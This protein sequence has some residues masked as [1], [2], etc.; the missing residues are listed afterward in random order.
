MGEGGVQAN[1]TA[2]E[3]SA[4]RTSFL[5]QCFTVNVN[6]TFLTPI[7]V[8]HSSEDILTSRVHLTSFFSIQA[9][10][11]VRQSM[12]FSYFYMQ[13]EANDNRNHD[14]SMYSSIGVGEELT[15]FVGNRVLTK[16][17]I[18]RHIDGTS[19]STLDCKYSG[20]WGRSYDSVNAISHTATFR[21][22]RLR[23]RC[24]SSGC[25]C[26]LWSEGRCEHFEQFYL[27]NYN[28]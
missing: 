4:T 1:Q 13:A 12:P 8:S 19:T 5:F 7:V 26:I 24:Y 16:I 11:L 23:W 10:D 17:G 14:I 2:V 27:L 9:R 22:N 21:S 28:N 6:A 3:F 20:C 18:R 25:Y 15:L